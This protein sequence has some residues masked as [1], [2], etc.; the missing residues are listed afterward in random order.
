MGASGAMRGM[1]CTASGLLMGLEP[2]GAWPGAEGRGAS[3]A[4]VLG[5]AGGHTGGMARP[6]FTPSAE[7]SAAP[8]RVWYP[9]SPVA[10]LGAAACC[11]DG[12]PSLSTSGYKLAK[13]LP[14]RE[15]FMAGLLGAAA[16]LKTLRAPSSGSAAWLPVKLPRMRA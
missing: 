2:T 3:R 11:A 1:S 14:D 6:S 9:T 4:T 8:P 16:R 7:A 13:L 12:L 10:G 5:R 15:A